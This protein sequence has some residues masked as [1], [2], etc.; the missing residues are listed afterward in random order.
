MGD[1]E[2]LSTEFRR[3]VCGSGGIEDQVVGWGGGATKLTVLALEH[4]TPLMGTKE[5]GM[6][7]LQIALVFVTFLFHIHVFLSI[8]FTFQ[9]R[10]YEF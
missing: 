4:C 1:G 5:N 8:N 6:R 3:I 7:P 10:S 2:R 9:L